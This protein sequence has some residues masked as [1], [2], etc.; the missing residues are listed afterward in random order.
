M[1]F[2]CQ[3]ICSALDRASGL[4]KDIVNPIT[5]KPLSFLCYRCHGAFLR[6]N[7]ATEDF[8]AGI[9]HHLVELAAHEV[10]ASLRKSQSRR[11]HGAHRG[12]PLGECSQCYFESP[13][14]TTP[15]TR[16]AHALCLSVL[17]KEGGTAAAVYTPTPVAMP[18]LWPEDVAAV[19]ATSPPRQRLKVCGACRSSADSRRLT[20]APPPSPSS[21]P[22][23]SCP[24]L[25]SRG[26]G[27]VD[28]PVHAAP[29]LTAA[30][31]EAPAA[32]DYVPPAGGSG[33]CETPFVP[34]VR[35]AVVLGVSSSPRGPMQMME[36]LMASYRSLNSEEMEQ[37]EALM[38]THLR[39]V[40]PDCIF[41]SFRNGV[42]RRYELAR[43]RPRKAVVAKRQLQRRV[44]S[45]ARVAG[46]ATRGS[47]L[48]YQL[49][50]SKILAAARTQ[51]GV[52]VV[53]TRGLPQLSP[54]A[55]ALFTTKHSLSVATW[56]ALR[57]AYSGKES[58]LASREVLRAAT[59]AISADPGRQAWTDD[60][61]AHLVSLRDAL[62]CSLAELVASGQFREH[63]VCDTDGLPVPHTSAYRPTPE[64]AYELH[65]DQVADVHLCLG[66]DK[67]G[68]GV[69]TAKLVATIP[70]QER[71]MSRANSILLSTMPCTSDA[72]ADLHEMVGPWMGDL[73]ALLASGVSVNGSLRA[74]RLFPT[75]DLSFLSDFLGHKGATCRHPCVFCHVVGRPD[76]GSTELLAVC[77]SMQDVTAPPTSVRTRAELQAAAVSFADRPNDTLP[78]PVPAAE[79]RSIER[80]A[81]FDVEP[82]QIVPAPL[83]L[84]LRITGHAL[85]LGI[86]AVVFESGAAA[87]AEAARAVGVALLVSARVCPVP[88]HGGGFAGRDCHRIAQRSAAVCDALVGHLS[89][90][91]LTA[92]RRAWAEWSE[93]IS[94]LS[95]AEDVPVANVRVFQATVSRF[96]SGLRATFPWMSVTPKLHAL[97]H[98]A[99]TFLLRF[100]SL[101][102][103]AEQ[104]LEA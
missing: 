84:T 46:G 60:C 73:Q 99:P 101:G 6:P 62:E 80:C 20:A 12:I 4:V 45:V 24:G 93:V 26:P 94:V 72:N 57:K 79:H 47:S 37:L 10:A 71:P 44:R 41:F 81:V 82:R 32:S 29:A 8:L 58:G 36:A 95:R 65:A 102:S 54:R 25:N 92:L 48:C 87:G 75:G 67:G 89:D 34:V 35:G 31:E 51:T 83:H 90:A 103:Y 14:P 104:A 85:R 77:G 76:M 19:Q 1:Y 59:R 30:S 2:F 97:V 63:L 91:R 3:W 55:Q 98:H 64:A 21:S 39:S 53:P 88:Y 9:S 28:P 13:A 38:A 66:L 96:A 18:W 50:T 100:G 49:S 27:P 15:Q 86:E 5:G 70:N 69:S 42:N 17:H 43:G 7:R 61:G 74:V 11:I 33:G 23:T 78:I 40:R 56:S 16:P 52:S 22:T 68:I